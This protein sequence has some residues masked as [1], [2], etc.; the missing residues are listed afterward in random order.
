MFGLGLYLCFEGMV[1]YCLYRWVSLECKF[2]GLMNIV[3]WFRSRL[4]P[5]QHMHS[6]LHRQLFLLVT[7]EKRQNCSR[8]IVSCISAIQLRCAIGS[9]LL[10]FTTHWRCRLRAR[11]ARLSR[12]QSGFAARV[13]FIALHSLNPLNLTSLKHLPDIGAHTCMTCRLQEMPDLEQ[14]RA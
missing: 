1:D 9:V 11:L 2:W 14:Y 3:R 13:T 5:L 4:G 6:C 7:T 12:C 10:S 8:F